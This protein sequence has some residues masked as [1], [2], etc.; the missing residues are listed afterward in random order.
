LSFGNAPSHH[1]SIE[2]NHFIGNYTDRN[3][4]TVTNKNGET[5]TFPQINFQSGKGSGII[6]L[7]NS[8]NIENNR[9]D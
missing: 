7:E 8:V 1:I 5:H 4:N 3:S 9:W 6:T 2:N